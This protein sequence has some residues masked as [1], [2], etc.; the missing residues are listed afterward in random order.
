MW[1]VKNDGKKMDKFLDWLHFPIENYNLFIFM[2]YCTS[3]LNLPVTSTLRSLIVSGDENVANTF[4]H[5]LNGIL[6]RYKVCLRLQGLLCCVHTSHSSARTSPTDVTVP[7]CTFTHLQLTSHSPG[8]L[9][10]DQRESGHRLCSSDSQG[11]GGHTTLEERMS[12]W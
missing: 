2:W 3:L 5:L 9:L 8:P 12:R 4:S 6:S 11:V 1:H 10:S 7:Y